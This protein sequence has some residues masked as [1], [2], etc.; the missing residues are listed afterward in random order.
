MATTVTAQD[1]IRAPTVAERVMRRPARSLWSD[2]WRQFRRHRL[3]L[4]GVGTFAVLLVGTLLGPFIW[5]T[6][7][8]AIDYGGGLLSPSSH[9]PFVTDDPR[10]ALIE[11]TLL[12]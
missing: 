12:G 2:A 10:P 1:L 7:G 4:F 11:R 3:A 8:A 9:H 5:T 6:P